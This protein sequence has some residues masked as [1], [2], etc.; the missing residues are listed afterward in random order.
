L[1]RL[2]VIGPWFIF[3]GVL[4]SFTCVTSR[5]VGCPHHFG[6]I[7]SPLSYWFSSSCRRVTRTDTQGDPPPAGDSAIW[8]GWPGH[9]VRVTQ[10]LIRYS[11]FQE[12]LKWSYS[13]P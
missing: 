11:I 6:K 8:C 4:C 1:T 9:R 7:T 10:P 12:K 5:S 3:I 13:T 2:H